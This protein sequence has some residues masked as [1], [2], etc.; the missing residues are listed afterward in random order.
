MITPDP[1][2]L[3][4]PPLATPMPSFVSPMITPWLV[5]VAAIAP[6]VL[7]PKVAPLMVPPDWLETV[8]PPNTATPS[9]VWPMI[10]PWLVTVEAVVP[11]VFT[12]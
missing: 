12:P 10:T 5:T 4:V 9:F 6:V 1:A 11:V 2:L 3:M 7:T 8:P